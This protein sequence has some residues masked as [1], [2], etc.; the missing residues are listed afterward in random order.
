[1]DVGCYAIHG[2]RTLGSVG[3]GEPSVVSAT[4]IEREDAPG[5]DATMEADLVYPSGLSAHFVSSF[6]VPE[7]D[8]TMRITG[9]DGEAFAH[10]FCAGG[11]DDRIAVSVAGNSRI[12]EMGKK[13]SYT[14]Q[15][16][17]FAEHVRAGT[18][19]FN[20]AEDA[21]IQ[22]EFIDSVYRAA[23]MPTRPASTISH[24]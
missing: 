7:M 8:F 6:A 21:L 4:A 12:E 14:Y 18:P 3:G 2:L 13:S 11:I 5:V 22:A 15:L 10:N 23:G 19:I 24:S 20:D 16:E 9:S 1:M 17:A